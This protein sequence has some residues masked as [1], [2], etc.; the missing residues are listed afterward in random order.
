MMVRLLLPLVGVLLLGSGILLAWLRL[1]APSS[2]KAATPPPLPAGQNHRS[3]RQ[4]HYLLSDYLDLDRQRQTAEQISL[5]SQKL[6]DLR[7][8]E[9]ITKH[10]THL[11]AEQARDQKAWEDNKEAIAHWLRQRQ[12]AEAQSRPPVASPVDFHEPSLTPA[13]RRRAL[14]TKASAAT[15]SEP[16]A[17]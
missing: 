3:V 8:H 10:Q 16:V 15:A 5:H 11:A 6:S 12:E 9:Q 4:H 17:A 2:G 14:L 1:A 7:N 13:Q